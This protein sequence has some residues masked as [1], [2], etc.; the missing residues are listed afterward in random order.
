VYY[1]CIIMNMIKGKNR[2]QCVN[3]WPWRAKNGSRT[4]GRAGFSKRML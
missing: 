3:R 1:I 2:Q 4:R